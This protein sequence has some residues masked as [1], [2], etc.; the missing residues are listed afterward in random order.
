MRSTL[1]VFA[2]LA[3]SGVACTEQE[4]IKPLD[5]NIT[6][7]DSLS[8]PHG[9]F[10]ELEGTSEFRSTV[11]LD[12]GMETVERYTLLYQITTPG[13]TSTYTRRTGHRFV[14]AGGIDKRIFLFAPGSNEIY[15]FLWQEDS[16]VF[17]AKAPELAKPSWYVS[18]DGFEDTAILPSKRLFPRQAFNFLWVYEN[19]KWSAHLPPEDV[20]WCTDRNESNGDP[21][22]THNG[23]DYWT[24]HFSGCTVAFSKKTGQW[25]ADFTATTGLNPAWET[26]WRLIKELAAQPEQAP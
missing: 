2:L 12:T 7:T 9:T 13:G 4:E 6:T 26:G 11:E 17:H 21:I 15:E 3:L 22:R 18:D 19:G 24:Q 25:K 14:N 16:L 1:V 8:T 5:I 23:S 20:L 10:K